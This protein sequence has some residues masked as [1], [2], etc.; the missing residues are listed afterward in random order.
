MQSA[1]FQKRVIFHFSAT[2]I[3]QKRFIKEFE[4]V[5]KTDRKE[6]KP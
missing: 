6:T 4:F 1:F 5:S 3:I 2:F